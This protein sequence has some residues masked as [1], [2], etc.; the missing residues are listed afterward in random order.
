LLEHENLQRRTWFSQISKAIARI[1]EEYEDKVVTGSGWPPSW[2]RAFIGTAH[3]WRATV[4][5]FNYDTLVERAVNA[6]SFHDFEVHQN[7][8][9]RSCDVLGHLPPRS[10]YAETGPYST[11]RLLKL[12]GSVSFYHTSGDAAGLVGSLAP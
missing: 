11:F 4:I 3:G 6:S 12:H 7:N 9:V 1:I 5:T 2:L 8:Q 10:D